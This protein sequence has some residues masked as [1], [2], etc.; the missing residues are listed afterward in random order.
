VYPDA[1]WRADA[2]GQRDL[3]EPHP[4]AADVMLRDAEPGDL[5]RLQEVFRSS[6]L[7]NPGDRPH[8][9]AHPEVLELVLEP[10]IEG[11]MRVAVVD[12]RIVGFATIQ[13]GDGTAELDDLFVDPVWMRQGIG[14]LLIQDAAARA[15][16][17]GATRIEVTANEHALAF[18]EAA[19]FVRQGTAATQFGGAPRM[20][21]DLGDGKA[22]E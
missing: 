6:S 2:V 8:L 17:A 20:H 3:V 16:A 5:D 15:R 9:L 7:S 19:G 1:F 18:Y 22:S 13:P 11:R 4:P 14:R 10:I 12:E 21:L